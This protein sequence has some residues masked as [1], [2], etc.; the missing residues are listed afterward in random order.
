MWAGLPQ[1]RL[2]LPPR[3][4]RSTHVLR[5]VGRGV[6][7]CHC[8]IYLSA[9]D[10]ARTASSLARG[11]RVC[12]YATGARMLASVCACARSHSFIFATF[13]YIHAHSVCVCMHKHTCR[14][15]CASTFRHAFICGWRICV[16]VHECAV[17]HISLC[18][19]C[20]RCTYASACACILA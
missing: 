4:R 9:C 1:R 2:C 7:T 17:G 10:H 8:C 11:L 18:C 19:V 15:M 20:M 12:M 6:S 3:R 16:F 5:Q 14:L 13:V